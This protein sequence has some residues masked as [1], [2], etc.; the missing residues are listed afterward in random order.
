MIYSV[1]EAGEKIIRAGLELMEKGL[2]TRTW[3]NI[4]ARLSD[5]TFLVTPSGR[6]YDSLTPSDLVTVNIKDC[7]YEGTITPSSESGIHADTYKLRSDVDFIIHTHQPYASAIGVIGTDITDYENL[8]T[9]E[10]SV[11]GQGLSYTDILGELIPC[12][13]YGMSSSKYLRDKVRK[14]LKKNRTAKAILLRN[15]GVIAVGSDYEDA[16]RIAIAL[17]EMCRNRYELICANVL[18]HCDTTVDIRLGVACRE[19][20]RLR[21][22]R[23]EEEAVFATGSLNDAGRKEVPRSMKQPAMLYDEIFRDPD[24][25]AAMHVL[26]PF[27]CMYG[28]IGKRRMKCYFDDQAQILGVDV[29]FLPLK[30]SFGRLKGKKKIAKYM[31]DRN[32]I[33]TSTGGAVVT[34]KTMEDAE[35]AAFVLE[36]ASMAAVLDSQ[37]GILKPVKKKIALKEREAYI[38]SYSHLREYNVAIGDDAAMED[39]TITQ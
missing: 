30:M 29:R 35:A 37:L 17:E 5:T 22:T 26:T 4:S 14:C 24:V 7:S 18:E 2:I 23:D 20:G 12:A 32:A 15:H 11:V 21:C 28:N 33:F 31:S 39:D 16:F 9:D 19:E 13:A 25:N 27:T 34:G 38:S 36:K 1:E 8:K 10:N 3:G 6:S